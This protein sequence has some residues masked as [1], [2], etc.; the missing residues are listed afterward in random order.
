M[1][2]LYLTIFISTERSGW[3]VHV[4]NTYSHTRTHNQ[5][6][7][8]NIS[9][10]YMDMHLLYTHTYIYI[11]IYI[12]IVNL[13]SYIYVHMH[14]LTLIYIYIYICTVICIYNMSSLKMILFV[15]FFFFFFLDEDAYVSTCMWYAVHGYEI[16]REEHVFCS[17]GGKF[18][19]KIMRKMLMTKCQCHFLFVWIIK[20]HGNEWVREYEVLWSFDLI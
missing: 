7:H 1:A 18:D 10:P 4:Q 9:R 12:Y 8:T 20:L 2:Q 14:V 19:L 3:L 6:T 16:I 15:G 11:Y 13:L 17:N 5:H